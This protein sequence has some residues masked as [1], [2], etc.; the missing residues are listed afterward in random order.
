MCFTEIHACVCACENKGTKNINYLC[1]S[2]ELVKVSGYDF[3]RSEQLRPLIDT[4]FNVPD[5]WLTGD[6]YNVTRYSS[7]FS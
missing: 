5:F 7:K 6:T 4:E 1:L 3:P 2:A